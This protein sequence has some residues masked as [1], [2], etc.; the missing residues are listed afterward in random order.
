MNPQF[1]ERHRHGKFS[2]SFSN[3]FTVLSCMHLYYRIT[4]CCHSDFGILKRFTQKSMSGR[5]LNPMASQIRS[6]KIC[7]H[8]CRPI[9]QIAPVPLFSPPWKF[10]LLEIRSTRYSCI[11]L[12]D[13]RRNPFPTTTLSGLLIKCY[14]VY[15]DNVT[16]PGLFRCR[17]NFAGCP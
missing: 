5:G 12:E 11:L 17:R 2:S 4:N 15:I 10:A 6:N 7:L 8:N 16:L 14:I 13:V 3:H 1:T 9:S